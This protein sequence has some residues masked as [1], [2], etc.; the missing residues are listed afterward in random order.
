MGIPLWRGTTAFR[1]VRRG[2]GEEPRSFAALILYVGCEVNLLVKNACL[3]RV[4]SSISI[5]LH[6]GCRAT[7]LGPEKRS[8]DARLGS[9]QNGMPGIAYVMETL[10]SWIWFDDRC[11]GHVREL[12]PLTVTLAGDTLSFHMD[13]SV[14]LN[15]HDGVC[16][17]VL[18]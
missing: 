12:L 7:N 4:Y 13:S 18:S 5:A 14:P 11:R 3:S 17:L 9:L 6:P 1:A 2:R 8:V 16:A 15:A 10:K